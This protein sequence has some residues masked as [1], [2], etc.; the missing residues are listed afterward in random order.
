MK[1]KDE[2]NAEE[3]FALGEI[4]QSTDNAFRS[5]PD[6]SAGNITRDKYGTSFKRTSNFAFTLRKSRS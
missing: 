4:E 1:N 2:K 3:N 6:F 5:D